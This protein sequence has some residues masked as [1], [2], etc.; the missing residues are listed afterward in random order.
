MFLIFGFSSV[1]KTGTRSLRGKCPR[2]NDI[3]NFQQFYARQFLSLFFVPI[4][5]ISRK[6]VFFS[7]PTCNYTISDEMAAE[8][9]ILRGGE[10]TEKV[11]ENTI[12]VFCPRCEGGMHIP[13]REQ[14][15][16]VTCPHCSMEFLVKGIKGNIPTAAV[17]EVWGLTV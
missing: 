16:K 3:R 2:C 1:K 17:E 7:C 12:I 11:P 8:S 4:L 9:I 14:R 15:Q 5:P 13:L 10:N 6:T